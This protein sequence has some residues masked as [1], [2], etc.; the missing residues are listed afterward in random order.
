MDLNLMAMLQSMFGD[1]PAKK[2]A[3]TA[4][5]E[6]F[7]ALFA[8]T[9]LSNPQQPG[10]AQIIGGMAPPTGATGQFIN[11]PLA[12]LPAAPVVEGERA[13][14]PDGNTS[15]PNILAPEPGK[16]KKKDDTMAMSTEAL[17]KMQ[18]MWDAQSKR[19]LVQAPA[20]GAGDSVGGRTVPAPAALSISF[21]PPVRQG[22]GRLIY[23]A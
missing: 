22:F 3:Q 5:P 4:A 15:A 23:G 21:A 8:N 10:F 7:D 20:A 9:N 11:L 14:T 18:Q 6:M 12:P 16:G 13:F 19:Q 17:A 1:D 2:L